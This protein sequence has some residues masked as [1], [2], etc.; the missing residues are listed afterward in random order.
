[1]VFI[2]NVYGLLWAIAGFAAAVGLQS[3]GVGVAKD[4]TYFIEA[5]VLVV[6]VLDIGYR[7]IVGKKSP[8]SQEAAKAGM[9]GEVGNHWLLGPRLGGNLMFLP[10]W[11]TAILLLVWFKAIG[12]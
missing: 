1:M 2:F 9:K 7:S 12:A 5:A 10:A 8:A 6:M 3:I 11:A 4:G